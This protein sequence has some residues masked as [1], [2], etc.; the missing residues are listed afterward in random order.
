MLTVTYPDTVIDDRK[1]WTFLLPRCRTG[2]AVIEM[3]ELLADPGSQ[4][5]PLIHS[6]SSLDSTIN[7]TSDNGLDSTN[8]PPFFLMRDD[9]IIVLMMTVM[10]ERSPYSDPYTIRFAISSSKLLD[11]VYQHDIVDSRM[12]PW[13]A[14]GPQSTRAEPQ[15]DIWD[16][17]WP[18]CV[19]G[20]RLIMESSWVENRDGQMKRYR[21]VSFDPPHY[22]IVVGSVAIYDYNQSALRHALMNVDVAA[23]FLGAFPLEA[24]QA[25]DF[26]DVKPFRIGDYEYYVQPT[27]LPKDFAK[28]F[29]DPDNVLTSLP[30]RVCLT[31]VSVHHEHQNLTDQVDDPL[32]DI[33]LSTASD[34]VM[35]SEDSII[36]VR[37]SVFFVYFG[38]YQLTLPRKANPV[39]TSSS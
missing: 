39:L 19:Y 25:V 2:S 32:V 4:W 3:M 34:V 30:Y 16:G 13:T 35:L 5:T 38:M 15:N 7:T 23:T 18:C 37:V 10:D 1:R 31:S 29:D 8:Q 21:P 22:D 17:R 9:R 24:G 12:F 26:Q 33:G 11:I 27:K 20:T 36:L 28:F 6:S 14:W